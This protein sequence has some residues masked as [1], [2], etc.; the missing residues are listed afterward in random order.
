MLSVHYD[1]LGGKFLP[2]ASGARR[3]G[4]L[5]WGLAALVIA[6]LSALLWFGLW[7]LIIALL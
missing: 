7:H 4:R 5:P 2:A 1:W 3:S 6:A